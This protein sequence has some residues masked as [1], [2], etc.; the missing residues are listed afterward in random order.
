MSNVQHQPRVAWDGAR[1][2]VRAAGRPGFAAFSL[3][4]RDLLGPEI[5]QQLIVTRD[6]LIASGIWD[7]GDRYPMDV[8][9]GKWRWRLQDLLQ[10]RPDLAGAVVDLTAASFEL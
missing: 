6:Y 2:F 1:A 4:V 8:E 5:Q 7:D 10:N 9:A 3:R